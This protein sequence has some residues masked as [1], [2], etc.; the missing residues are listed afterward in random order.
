MH[1]HKATCLLAALVCAAAPAAAQDYAAYITP[2]DEGPSWAIE[3]TM[4]L[5]L[6]IGG[7]P[8]PRELTVVALTE[9]LGVNM[10]KAANAI[11]FSGQVKFVTQSNYNSI[12]GPRDIAY[13]SCETPEGDSFI[14]P[15]K[16]LN[17]LMAAKPRA[18]L[19]YSTKTQYCSLTYN[20]LDYTTILT[21]ADV[22]ES[23]WLRT[24]LQNNTDIQGSISGKTNPS[25]ESGHGHTK[26][27]IAMSILYTITGLVTLLFV[28]IITTGAVRA[29]RYPERYGPRGAAGGR[30]RQ[31]RAKGIARAV[32]ETMPIVKF[33]N[34]QPPKPDPELELETGT[35][36]GRDI[37]P[38]RSN[39]NASSSAHKETLGGVTAGAQSV[40]TPR[41]SS[42]PEPAGDAYLG[43]TICTEDFKVGEDVRVLP[44]SHQFHPSCIDPWLVNVSGT[45]PLW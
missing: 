44:C 4:Q 32:L 16:M 39:S 25:H 28:A 38:H 6:T 36:D 2:S 34:Q 14:Q 31:S 19:L 24:S 41:S 5:N 35:T 43:C 26:S 45:C 18:I 22:D 40:G 33:N 30:P 7:E 3:A 29:H 37:G 13:L 42:I 17:D 8:L 1:A 27:S 11:Q 12:N 10:P 23:K 20:T 15:D 21:M 9:N